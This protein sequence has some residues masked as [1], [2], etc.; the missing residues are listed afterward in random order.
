MNYLLNNALVAE[1]G[2][3]QGKVEYDDVTTPAALMSKGI[4]DLNSQTIS[5]TY[6]VVSVD[7]S[8]IDG[9]YDQ[10]KIGNWHDLENPISDD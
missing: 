2:V 5:M 7:Y 1:F 8:L 10:L 4:T 6:S 3:I 9:S